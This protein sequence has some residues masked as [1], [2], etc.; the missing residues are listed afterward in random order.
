[1]KRI[2]GTIA[3]TALAAC[4][5]T[6]IPL[7]STGGGSE[8]E[9][10]ASAPQVLPESAPDT[11]T[12]TN[13]T[14]S[15]MS[16][17]QDPHPADPRFGFVVRLYAPETDLETIKNNQAEFLAQ[18]TICEP[19]EREAFE[20]TTRVLLR[21][22]S[23]A[24]SV[25][26]RYALRRARVGATYTL[27]FMRIVRLS[28]LDQSETILWEANGGKP[29]TITE[30]TK[31]VAA[32][33]PE[34]A[35]LF[36]Y[37]TNNRKLCQ[38]KDESIATLRNSAPALQ[39]EKLRVKA[40]DDLEVEARPRVDSPYRYETSL[41][42][43]FQKGKVL[44]PPAAEVRADEPACHLNFT[45]PTDEPA[46]GLAIAKN[47]Q[48]EFKRGEIA[49]GNSA[50]VPAGAKRTSLVASAEYENVDYT[51]KKGGLM[52]LHCT[53]DDVILSDVQAAF[54]GVF[55]YGKVIVTAE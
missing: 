19:A 25:W 44:M 36:A 55:G 41:E 42:F 1:M 14:V 2:I 50:K 52:S 31:A 9:T 49:S 10:R 51:A 30:S 33:A 43:V 13:L 5:Q 38:R 39:F 17:T 29:L 32:S 6:D 54:D 8:I 26:V 15:A 23:D 40:M 28:H 12:S 20:L 7:A 3:L 27:D 34:F 45:A 53:G 37:D 48:M 46:K 24:S 11:T 18:Q 16:F 47:T 21:R 35:V 4:H 22:E